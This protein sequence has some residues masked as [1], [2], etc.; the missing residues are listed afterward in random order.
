M[1]S[2]SRS[3]SLSGLGIPL[4]FLNHGPDFLAPQTNEKKKKVGFYVQDPQGSD[5]AGWSKQCLRSGIGP[6]LG[7]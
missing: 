5:P 7:C 1:G 6:G 2:N 4:S 3:L